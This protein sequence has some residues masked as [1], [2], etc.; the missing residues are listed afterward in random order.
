MGLPNSTM[1]RKPDQSVT[2][3]GVGHQMVRQKN[4]TFV[5]NPEFI[6]DEDICL[7]LSHQF[8]LTGKDCIIRD[9]ND[10]AHLTIQSALGVQRPL[11]I[12]SMK[13]K[14]VVKVF[15]NNQSWFSG[16]SDRIVD[17]EG[18]TIAE[19]REGGSWYR[20]KKYLLYA[21]DKTLLYKISP[22]YMGTTSVFVVKNPKGEVVAR[23]DGRK[24]R[25]K[26]DLHI[27]AGND[28]AAMTIIMVKIG[29]WEASLHQDSLHLYPF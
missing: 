21:P 20:K 4:T 6:A 23:M 18:N 13:N 3:S 27:G 22:V 25:G 8:P 29:A 14:V 1:R 19:L 26:Y 5:V 7:Q 11:Q 28:V 2:E 24:H 9:E 16:L 10:K 17:A 15:G 12:R